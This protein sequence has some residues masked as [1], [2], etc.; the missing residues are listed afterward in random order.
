MAGKSLPI[1]IVSKY[2]L[3]EPTQIF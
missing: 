1:Y 2:Q 3:R